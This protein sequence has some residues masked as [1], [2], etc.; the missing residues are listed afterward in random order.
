MEFMNA[1]AVCNMDQSLCY[2]WKTVSLS[3]AKH[4]MLLTASDL[5]ICG[6]DQKIERNNEGQYP[7]FSVCFTALV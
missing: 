7:L 5:S 4:I 3:H 6:E 1:S 2:F